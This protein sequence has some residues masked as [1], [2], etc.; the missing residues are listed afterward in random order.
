MRRSLW[1]EQEQRCCFL[2]WPSCPP[3]LVRSRCVSDR[4]GCGSGLTSF[5]PG[6]FR[7]SQAHI[8]VP[9]PAPSVLPALA[10]SCAAGVALAVV[11]VLRTFQEGPERVKLHSP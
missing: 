11:L 8:S 9:R 3:D 4:S 6:L 2:R 7:V 1:F 5:C 10:A